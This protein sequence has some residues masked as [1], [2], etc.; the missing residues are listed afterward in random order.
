MGVTRREFLKVGASGLTVLGVSL[1]RL[2]ARADPVKANKVAEVPVIW[3]ATGSCTGCSVSLLNTDSPTIQELLVSEVLP[4]KHV[5]LGFHATV[6]AGAGEP[7][8]H[9]ITDVVAKHKGGYV[10]VVDGATAQA[11]DGLY[12][13]IGEKD[14][15]PITGYEHVRDLGR[16]ALAVL[17]V[18]TCSSFGGIPAAAP[19]PTGAMSVKQIFE[20]EKISTPLV[21]IP[22]CPPHP[23]WI[24]GPIATVLL[25]GL[26]GL[27]L[28]DLGRPKPFYAPLIHDNCPYRGQFDEGRLAEH[29]GEH[30]CLARL[31][32]KGPMTRADCST[33]QWNGGTNWCIGNGH[34][35][36]GCTEPQF[37]FA[38]S[39][40][41]P[42]KPA[43]MA[44][45]GTYPVTNDGVRKEADVDTYATIGLIGVG[46]FLA[47]A[48]IMAAGK[49]LAGDSS[50]KARGAEA[51]PDDATPQGPEATE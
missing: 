14:G 9:A 21:H 17:A 3:M 25:G 4:G 29:F 8:M 47:G 50:S 34:P 22:G 39:M 26:E 37:P 6:M 48:G 36:I 1:Y 13:S 5:S 42:V 16:D 38:T 28:D 19:N 40:F 24:V 31:G 44:F 12:C 51:K 11:E 7:A 30:G 46:G 10:L 20:R 41:E 18:G 49:Q 35:C 43:D 23:D 45:P 27:K 2:P 33:R 15:K 32:C